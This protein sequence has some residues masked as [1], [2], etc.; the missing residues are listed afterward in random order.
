MADCTTVFKTLKGFLPMIIIVLR[1][2]TKSF[3]YNWA[4]DYEAEL[5]NAATKDIKYA[6]I[7]ID[8]CSEFIKSYDDK[9]ECELTE[10]YSIQAVGNRSIEGFCCSRLCS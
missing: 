1:R 4:T 7:R 5:G 3:I 2:L 8:Y 10:G 9:S 6:Q